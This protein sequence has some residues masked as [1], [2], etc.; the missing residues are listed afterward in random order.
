MS[1]VVGVDF[2]KGG[3]VAAQVAA[4]WAQAAGAELILVHV[5]ADAA[6]AATAE[7]AMPTLL[8]TLPRAQRLVKIGEPAATLIEVART[9]EAKLIVVGALAEPTLSPIIL[10]SVAERVVWSSPVPVAVIRGHASALVGANVPSLVGVDL[11]PA[12]DA[13]VAWMR[14]QRFFP[15]SPRVGHVWS[16]ITEFA[17]RKAEATLETVP[18]Q[19]ASLAERAAAKVRARSGVGAWPVEVTEGV[20]STSIGLARLMRTTGSELLVIGVHQGSTAE[21]LRSTALEVLGTVATSVVVVPELRKD[22]PNLPAPRHLVVATDLGSTG[23]RAVRWA[24]GLVADGGTIHLLHV[25]EPVY[26]AGDARRA[27][28]AALDGQLL[29]RVPPHVP[30]AVHTRVHVEEGAPAKVI[31]ALADAVGADLIVLGAHGRGALASLLLGS[32]SQ[33]VLRA[34]TRPVLVVP[35]D[36]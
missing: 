28:L 27:R 6:E 12:G 34:A 23:D 8:S 1:V 36:R 14:E 3:G 26:D 9:S 31:T 24:Y 4:S 21:R 35:P 30:P 10:G 11:G 20:L 15:A 16:D 25:T 19:P 5:A 29:D 32:T 17:A 7:A 33:D 13:A 22:D 18:Q 2:S